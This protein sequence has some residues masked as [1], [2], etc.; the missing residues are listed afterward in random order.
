MKLSLDDDNMSPGIED[1]TSSV[2]GEYENP[3]VRSGLAFAGAN[4]A[5]EAGGM[6][7]AY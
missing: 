3:L 5:V 1:N 2:E 4:H 7:M 6:M